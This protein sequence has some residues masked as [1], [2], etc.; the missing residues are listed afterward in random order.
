MRMDNGTWHYGIRMP[1]RLFDMQRSHARNASSR[2]R[3]VDPV[4]EPK[5]ELEKQ[6]PVTRTGR[7]RRVHFGDVHI[8]NP[9]EEDYFT[10]ADIEIRW[11]TLDHLQSI[12]VDAREWGATIRR[13][14]RRD[15]NLTIAYRKTTYM[16]AHDFQSLLSLPSTSPDQDLLEWCSCEDGR[17]GLERFSSKEFILNRKKDLAKTRE[18][19]LLEQR[20]QA[21]CG[22]QDAEAIACA[23]RKI[24]R[25]ARTFAQFLG[26]ADAKHLLRFLQREGT[27][28][29]LPERQETV[30][31]QQFHA[32]AI[33]A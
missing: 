9:D 5:H 25:R 2:D 27:P 18:S 16:L 32:L 3:F 21:D 1:L 22:V 17:R 14:G 10:E 12:K 15:C 11:W 31:S 20:N 29:V 8:L 13:S 19:V 28:V 6:S 4:L 24:S 26:Q 33:V 23:S 7:K 30:P